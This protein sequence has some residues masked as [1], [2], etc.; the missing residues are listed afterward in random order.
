MCV[1]VCVCVCERLCEPL[2]THAVRHSWPRYSLCLPANRTRTTQR[3]CMY[4]QMMV[5]VGGGRGRGRGRRGEDLT[6]SPSHII[7]ASP[8][9]PLRHECAMSRRALTPMKPIRTQRDLPA[10][11]ENPARINTAPTSVYYAASPSTTHPPPAPPRV[12]RAH[13]S[14]LSRSQRLRSPPPPPVSPP[15]HHHH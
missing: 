7:R 10:P 4:A 14:P 13:G 6:Q 3:L 9:T 2:L 8:H 5:C 11:H 12:C 1:C 15:H